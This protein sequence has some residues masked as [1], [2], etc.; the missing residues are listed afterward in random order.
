[1]DPKQVAQ[2]EPE[3]VPTVSQLLSELD[4]LSA[5]TEEGSTT[6]MVISEAQSH[7]VAHNAYMNIAGPE[8]TS[9]KPY[10]DMLNE[11]NKRILQTEREK[12]MRKFDHKGSFTLWYANSK[13]SR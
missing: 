7:T 8:N 3:K 1:V 2:F 5:T 12:K 11:H 4:S 6:G 10:I 13:I 9:I